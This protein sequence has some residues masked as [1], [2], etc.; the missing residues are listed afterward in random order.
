MVSA[1]ILVVSVD[2]YTANGTNSI[3]NELTDGLGIYLFRLF[4]LI[5][6]CKKFHCLPCLLCSLRAISRTV[7]AYAFKV[8]RFLRP[9]LA[10]L[11]F[12]FDHLNPLRECFSIHTFRLST[13]GA[14][15]PATFLMTWLVCLYTPREK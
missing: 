8:G 14:A 2:I 6:E 7:A 9:S 12:S 4:A 13:I 3:G 5:Q 11:C 10:Y 15:A 1:S